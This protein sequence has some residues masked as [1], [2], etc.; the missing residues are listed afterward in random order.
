M[1]PKIIQIVGIPGSG[2]SYILSKLTGMPFAMLS[3]KCYDTDDYIT[4]AYLKY[5]KGNVQAIAKK[6]FLRDIQG[7][8][9]P[10][11][12]AGILF[13]IPGSTRIFIKMSQSELQRAYKQVTRR[14]IDKW[15]AV[16]HKVSYD[17]D[18]LRYKYHLNAWSPTASLINYKMDYKNALE[19]EKGIGAI[20]LSQ[21]EIIEKIKN[22]KI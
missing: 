2:K 17:P 16:A 22:N 12:L 8:R 4:K 9:K 18:E 19:F 6:M 3:L 10:I 7:S 21:A 11:V 1:M 5:P 20:M 15:K 13:D 14:E